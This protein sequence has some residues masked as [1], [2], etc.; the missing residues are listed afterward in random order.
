MTQTTYR[1]SHYTDYLTIK[2][3][4]DTSVNRVTQITWKYYSNNSM[5]HVV[6]YIEKNERNNWSEHGIENI[7]V[8]IECSG[9]SSN[10]L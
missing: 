8:W 6:Q 1:L 4:I 2:F 7:G 9:S 10:S 3:L 5:N